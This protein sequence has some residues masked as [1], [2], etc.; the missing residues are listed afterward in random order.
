MP[1]DIE[2]I[3]ESHRVAR[4]LRAA[5]KPIWNETVDARA[6]HNDDLPLHER[7]RLVAENIKASRW[8]K[9]RDQ[10]GFDEFGEFVEDLAQAE[11]AEE[12]DEFWDLIYDKADTDRVW[13]KTF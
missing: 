6:L 1:R 5:G 9:N 4:E 2:S 3:V 10:S 11:T 12:F 7:F 13:I 8:Y